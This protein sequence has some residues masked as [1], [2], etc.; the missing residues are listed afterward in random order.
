MKR[1]ILT[2]AV[3]FSTLTLCAQ[4]GAPLPGSTEFH[5]HHNKQHNKQ[6]TQHPHHQHQ[7]QGST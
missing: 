2:V 6:K 5:K 1:L 7:H 4:T 3:L